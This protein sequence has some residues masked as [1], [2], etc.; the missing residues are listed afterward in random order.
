[1]IENTHAAHNLRRVATTLRKNRESSSTEQMDALS[2]GFSYAENADRLWQSEQLSL[3]AGTPLW[4]QAS[5]TQRLALNHLWWV[6]F[7][8]LISAAET[9]TIEY[10]QRCATSFFVLRG[11]EEVCLELDLETSQERYHIQAFRRVMEATEQA[12][13]G[14]PLFGGPDK[15]LRGDLIERV[16]RNQ[17]RLTSVALQ[18]PVFL[19]NSRLSRSP[20]LASQY[21]LMRGLLNYV[22]KHKE[23]SAFQLH[24][25]LT[26]RGEAVPVPTAVVHHHYIDEGFHT[27]VSQLLS[28][29]IYRDFPKPPALELRVM[30]IVVRAFQRGLLNHLGSLFGGSLGNDGELLPT[31][32]TLLRG[33]LFGMSEREAI[34]MLERCFCQEH[35]GFHSSARYRERWLIAARQSLADIEHLDAD[36]RELRVVQA[37]LGDVLAKNRQTFHTFQRA[38][39][40]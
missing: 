17:S 28:H 31:M 39:V 32:A 8:H 22:A 35:E 29:E 24:Q 3:F 18:A 36:V 15:P 38:R 2:R 30:N 21:F 9:H 23:G 34:S 16:R 7:Y 27:A 37:S 12:L 11:Y 26:L 19:F 13:L 20:F 40:A 1:M 10:N 6:G 5:P 4:E 33:P 25:E 14:A